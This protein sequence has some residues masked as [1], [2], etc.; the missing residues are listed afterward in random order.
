MK[1]E[2]D[3]RKAVIN[4]VGELPIAYRLSRATMRESAQENLAF[5]P[6]HLVSG[7]T[8]ETAK[9]NAWHDASSVQAGDLLP[10]AADWPS[11]EY[12]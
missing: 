9:T 12:T 8:R 5:G 7:S 1:D 10:D 11:G 3:L 6:A 4:E 2:A